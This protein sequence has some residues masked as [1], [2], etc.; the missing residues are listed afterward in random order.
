MYFYNVFFF[1][2]NSKPFSSMTSGTFD[3]MTMA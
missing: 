1:A 2:T 3:G